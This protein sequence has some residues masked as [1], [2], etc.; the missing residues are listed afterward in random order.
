MAGITKVPQ[1]NSIQSC[2]KQNALT[3][4]DP[5]H[6]PNPSKVDFSID[7]DKKIVNELKSMDENNLKDMNWSEFTK[8]CDLGSSRSTNSVRNRTKRLFRV[9][10]KRT[11]MRIFKITEEFYKKYRNKWAID[12]N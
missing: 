10:D 1:Q 7:E 2:T 8:K 6:N 11:A 9:Y 12:R 3:S 4:D 5:I